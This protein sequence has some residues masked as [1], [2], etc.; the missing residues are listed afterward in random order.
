LKLMFNKKDRTGKWFHDDDGTEGYT[1]KIPP[2]TA[3][4]WDEYKGEWVIIPHE[5]DTDLVP[6]TGLEEL[7]NNGLY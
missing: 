2:D 6:D 1:E 3:H 4:E 5:P 7:I